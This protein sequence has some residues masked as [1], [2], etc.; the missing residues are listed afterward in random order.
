VQLPVTEALALLL[1]IPE[2]CR[3]DEHGWPP[4]V[5]KRSVS[6][7][8]RRRRAVCVC[9]MQR[10]AA[11]KSHFATN[12]S[13]ARFTLSLLILAAIAAHRTQLSRHQAPYSC[14]CTSNAPSKI[15][16]T[17]SCL[18][19][20]AFLSWEFRGDYMLR[21]WSKGSSRRGSMKVK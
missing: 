5:A 9:T 11:S 17:R 15:Q 21:T 3:I 4:R 2:C 20:A 6:N 19:E 16:D 14:H 10:V 18:P 7:G 13:P 1:K 12:L 8:G